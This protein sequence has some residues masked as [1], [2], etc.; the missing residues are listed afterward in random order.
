MPHARSFAP[1]EHSAGASLHAGVVC[2]KTGDTKRARTVGHKHVNVIR[3]PHKRHVQSA[4]IAHF[5][6]EKLVFDSRRNERTGTEPASLPGL[7]EPARLP[8]L[9]AMR[10]AVR[11]YPDDTISIASRQA[12]DIRALCTCCPRECQAIHKR[13]CQR[14]AATTC[15]GWS[16][17]KITEL[18]PK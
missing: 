3:A 12:R 6:A 17:P 1:R 5:A 11:H 16:G 9:A 13:K 7:C 18:R 8:A 4:G 10:C 14:Q 15:S 2:R